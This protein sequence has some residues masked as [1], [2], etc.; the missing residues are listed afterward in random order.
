[1]DTIFQVVLHLFCIC[2]I[3]EK[4]LKYQILLKSIR[5]EPS[6]S[7]QTDGRQTETHDKAI[8]AYRNF[9]KSD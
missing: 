5:W 9:A 4:A 8:V 6:C 3:F 7:M 2:K 1:M